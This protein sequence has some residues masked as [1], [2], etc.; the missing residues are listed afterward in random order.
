VKAV[1]LAAGLGNRLR[2]L[3]DTTPKCLVPIGRRALLDIWLDA[4]RDLGVDEVLVNSHHLADQVA[5]H[6]AQRVGGPPVRLMHEET[7]RGS[8]GTLRAARDLLYDDPWFL[9]VNADNLTDYDLADLVAAHTGG[10]SMATLTAFHTQRPSAC[11]ILEVDDSGCLVG[12]EEKPVRPLS[13]LANAGL[14]AFSREVLDLVDGPEPR[15]IG[16]HLLPR[17]VGR[18]RVVGI[19]DAY[20]RDIGTPEALAEARATWREGV[21]R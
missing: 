6:L 7:L 9:A 16:T 5:A 3:T 13:D 4:L 12:F 20:L 18:A 10:V 14:Y 11:G 2:P 15:D 17:L 1:L 19:G 21:I 8:A